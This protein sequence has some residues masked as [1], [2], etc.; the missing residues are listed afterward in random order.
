MVPV[1]CRCGAGGFLPGSGPGNPMQMEVLTAA[2]WL[3]TVTGAES[4]A[5]LICGTAHVGHTGQNCR[6][7]RIMY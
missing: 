3:G 4:A 5:T 7:N 1:V 2:A 6:K